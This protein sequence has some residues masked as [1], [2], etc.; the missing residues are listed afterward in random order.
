MKMKTSKRI[1]SKRNIN[2]LMSSLIPIV[3]KIV[4]KKIKQIKSCVMKKIPSNKKVSKPTKAVK[5]TNT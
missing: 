5:V 3:K 2:N 4:N 1:L